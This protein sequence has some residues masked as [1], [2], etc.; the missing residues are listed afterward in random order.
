MCNDLSNL[1]RI[2]DPRFGNDIIED[3]ILLRRYVR[4][5]ESVVD[6]NIDEDQKKSLVLVHLL[7][8]YWM[9]TENKDCLKMK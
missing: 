1:A 7:S 9:K 4:L 8:F 5:N 6:K 3:S 2:L